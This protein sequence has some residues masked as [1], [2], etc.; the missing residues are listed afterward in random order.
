MDIKKIEFE[1]VVEILLTLF[2]IVF[3]TLFAL[4][5]QKQQYISSEQ[6]CDSLYGYDKWNWME[7]TGRGI[8]KGYIGQCW[9][10]FPKENGGEDN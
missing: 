2:I 6:Y 5:I 4:S 1:E 8:C 7:T 10:C 9:Q 3:I